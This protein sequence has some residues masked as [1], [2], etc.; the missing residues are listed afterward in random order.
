MPLKQADVA[1]YIEFRLRAAGYH[2]P[3]PFTANAIKLIAEVSEGLS[4]R[5]N[6]LADKSLLAAYSAA[7]HRVDSG[8]VRS[9]IQDARFSPLHNNKKGST[10]KRWSTII[11]GAALSLAL[12][13]LAV[14]L[15]TL[16]RQSVAELPPDA[17][18]ATSAAAP[19]AMTKKQPLAQLHPAEANT[20]DNIHF[21]PLTR[22]YFAQFEQWIA[23][24]PRRD[25]FIQLLA[26]DAEHTGEVEGFLARATA[27][28]DPKELRA[29]R[30]SLSGRDRVGVIY[31]DYPTREAAAAA[32]QSLPDSIQAAQPFP[33][34]VSRLQ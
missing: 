10:M 29:Y 8:E 18:A 25:Y 24:A 19:Q 1:N 9:A 17:P 20:A 21:G 26:T 31:G 14:G 2:G 16:R 4:R 28:L 22:Q 7:S 11:G 6:I 13:A 5:I 15:G 30:S 23:T 33:R 27:A 12:L 34:Q 32:M 3:N